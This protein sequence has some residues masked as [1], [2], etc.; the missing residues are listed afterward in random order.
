MN[1]LAMAMGRNSKSW[2]L[3][4]TWMTNYIREKIGDD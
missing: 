3:N 1:M 2:K 4:S